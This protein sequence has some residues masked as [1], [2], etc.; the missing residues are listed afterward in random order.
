MRLLLASLFASLLFTATALADT[1][2]GVRGYVYNV[3]GRPPV[4]PPLS[5][6]LIS[7]RS[8]EASAETTTDARGF[9]FFLALPPGYY[10]I[11]A[12]RPG[13]A[14]TSVI[15]CVSAGSMIDV[16]IKMISELLDPA[17]VRWRALPLNPLQTA[18]VY[19][20]LSGDRPC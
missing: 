5:G 8:P 12:D 3:N 15:R 16:R 1:T 6:V 19:N 18:D 9:F 11:S 13:F 7:V 10:T 4:P 20:I 17:Y 2:G 14:P